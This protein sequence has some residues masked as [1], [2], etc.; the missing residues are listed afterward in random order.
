M[1]VQLNPRLIN[2]IKNPTERV[3]EYVRKQKELN[4]SI[5]RI[6]ELL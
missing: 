6:K 5:T 3:Q 2:I 4:E 1:A